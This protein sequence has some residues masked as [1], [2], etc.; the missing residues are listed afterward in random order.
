MLTERVRYRKDIFITS[1]AHV[2]DNQPVFAEL[3]SEV[4]GAG[5]GVAGL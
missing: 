4:D 3:F 1:S 2:H 5:D